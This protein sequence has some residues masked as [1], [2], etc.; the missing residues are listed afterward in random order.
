MT[1]ERRREQILDVTHAIVLADGFHSATPNRIATE[2]GVTR[3]VLYQQFG[4]LAGVFVALIDREAERAALQFLEAIA[5]PPGALD[6]N[7][8]VSTFEGV[9]RAL[10]ANPATW[11]LFLA[12]PEGAPPELHQ[13]LAAAQEAVRGY[14]QAELL[15]AYPDLADPDYTAR[16]MHAVGRELLQLRLTDPKGATSERL[17]ALVRD[18]GAQSQSPVPTG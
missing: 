13:R 10:D 8:F 17:L 3:P 16:I 5:Q 9:L 2:A 11:Q 12:P 1:A 6:P 15:R 4:D 7:P 14:L 18:L